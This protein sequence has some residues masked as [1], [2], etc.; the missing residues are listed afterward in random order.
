MKGKINVTCVIGKD[1]NTGD[2][3]VTT[4]ATIENKEGNVN[5]G[6]GFADIKIKPKFPVSF[7]TVQ[8]IAAKKNMLNHL[9]D[10]GGI[11]FKDCPAEF[12][13]AKAQN[14]DRYYY[15]VIVNLGTEDFPVKRTFYLNERN[16]YYLSLFKPE[17]EFTKTD[18]I[19]N[20]SSEEETE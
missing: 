3:V 20:D 19:I 12:I 11:V 6:K 14:E 5:F 7:E 8:I 15:A 13:Y 18:S 1:Y 4:K 2:L 10:K 16:E 17:Y 9:E